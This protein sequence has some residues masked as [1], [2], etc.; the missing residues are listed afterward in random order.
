MWP[1]NKKI[2]AQD[3]PTIPARSSMEEVKTEA[4]YW[5][6]KA[7]ENMEKALL[8]RAKAEASKTDVECLIRKLEARDR[9]LGALRSVAASALQKAGRGAPEGAATYHVAESDGFAAEMHSIYEAHGAIR[10]LSVRSAVEE[11]RARV[12]I[13]QL[14][15]IEKNRSMCVECTC[16]IVIDE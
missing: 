2:A 15:E 11:T 7:D 12:A 4:A 13:E 3:E 1:F 10:A 5:K 16:A 9:L 8:W 6:M 14:R